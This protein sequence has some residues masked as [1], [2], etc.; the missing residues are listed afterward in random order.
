MSHRVRIAAIHARDTTGDYMLDRFRAGEDAL[1]AIEATEL[2]DISG[3]RVLLLQCHIGR[4]TLCLVRR[5]ATVADLDFSSAA[6]NVARRLSDETGLKADFVEGTEDQAPDLT[7]GPFDLVFT[8]WGTICW[9]PDVKKWAKVIAMCWRRAGSFTS[10][11]LIRGLPCWKNT[12]EGL[13]PRTIFKRLPTNLCSSQ[14]R[15]RTL[16][17]RLSCRI[18]QPES[19]YIRSQQSSADSLMPDLQLRCFENTRCCLGGV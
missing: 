3:K 19:G 5:G 2:G 1:H 4:D 14:M 8:T 12:L 11:T 16:A 18:N 13:C 15:P 6:L 7:P 9:L 17:T 10:Q